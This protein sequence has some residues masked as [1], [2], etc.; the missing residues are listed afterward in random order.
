MPFDFALSGIR[1]A[2]NDLSIT[3]N[4]IANAST[5]GFKSSR[6]EFGDVYA[7]SVLGAGSNPIGSGL[8]LQDVSQLFTQGSVSF[9]ENE[10]DLAVNGNG[11]FVLQQNGEQFYSRAGAFGLD[12]EGYIVSNTG[13]VLQGF[14]A[15]S[16]GNISGL[17]DDLQ[18]QTSNLAPRP[19]TGVNSVLN[20]DSSEP[21]LQS[22]GRSF[23]TQ[24]NAIGVAQVGLEDSTTTTLSSDTD[25]TL[26]LATDFSAGNISFDL[27]L[28]AS[29]GNNGS[30]SILLNTAAGCQPAFRHSMIYARLPV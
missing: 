7:V 19:T 16:A 29:S 5:T 1:A 21:V 6:A 8:R 23:S 3:G 4:N 28:S 18:I 20:L 12:Q 22:T 9:T 24:G 15:D 11:F 13:A 2:S 10:L 17:Q 14:P 27:D 30:V 26:P 25:F